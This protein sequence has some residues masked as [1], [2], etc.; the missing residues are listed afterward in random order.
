MGR[1]SSFDQTIADEI[2]IRL[3]EGESLRS[4]CEPEEMPATSTIYRWV[5]TNE[6][7][8]EHY[9]HA[10]EDQGE[11]DA[12]RVGDIGNKVAQGLMDPAAGRVAM[13]AFKWSAG[14]RKPKKY[15]ERIDLNHGGQKDNPIM[16][17]LAEVSGNTF[18]PKDDE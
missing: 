15:G 17:L 13:D 14:K 11:S 4:I 3:A 6:T 12:D 9:T 18:S 10:R 1:P 7:F 8:R 16:A 5:S 2:C